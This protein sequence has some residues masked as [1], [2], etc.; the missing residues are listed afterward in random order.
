MRPQCHIRDVQSP[1]FLIFD[2]EITVIYTHH[3]HLS[4][5]QWSDFSSKLN[6]MS[7]D[8]TG[9]QSHNGLILADKISVFSNDVKDFQSHNGLILADY[10]LI[11]VLYIQIFQSHN[12]LI[13]AQFKLTQ[14]TRLQTFQSHN[15]LILAW[16]YK[17]TD[18]KSTRLNSSHTDISRMPSS[19]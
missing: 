15:G 9:F 4:I 11:N 6:A 14:L 5:P 16:Y 3:S 7:D 8:M 1:N 12:G 2:T 10:I 18:R 19:A 17:V 13:L